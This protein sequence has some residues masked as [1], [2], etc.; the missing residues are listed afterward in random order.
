[1]SP[2]QVKLVGDTAICR[3]A[4]VAYD[5]T[6]QNGR[7]L[8]PVIVIELGVKRAVI[9]DIA[10]GDYWL[11]LIFNQNFTTLLNKFGF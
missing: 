10:I 7:P 9:K 8:S 1:M 6:L 3:L 4:S 11:N 5:A 2:T